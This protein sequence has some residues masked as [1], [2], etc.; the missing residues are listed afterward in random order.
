[1]TPKS[2]SKIIHA[3][4][5]YE[6]FPVASFIIPKKLRRHVICVYNF[7]RL[8]DDVADEGELKLSERMR[9]LNLFRDVLDSQHELHTVSM[10]K[11]SIEEKIIFTS[12]SAKS[13]LAELKIPHY[14]LIN[15]LD[16][17]RYDADFKEFEN[18]HAIF[19]YCKNSANPIGRILLKIFGYDNLLDQKKKYLELIYKKSDAICTGLQMINF[20]QDATEDDAKGRTTFP[21]TIWPKKIKLLEKNQ[22]SEIS[23]K[24]KEFLVKEM[25]TK[26]HQKLLEGKDLPKLLKKNYSNYTFRFALEISLIIECGLLI[27]KK[28]M[29][30]PGQVWKTPPKL[31]FLD[32]PKLFLSALFNVILKR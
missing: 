9:L 10:E 8:A 20:A 27:S 2:F 7:A 18:W 19:E 26:G 25:I 28:I 4:G 22:F 15:L 13:S 29:D 5:H 31:K 21:R 23:Q 12:I 32:M 30:N 17:F 3:T 6:N 16:A 24:N 14:L 11:K 1:M